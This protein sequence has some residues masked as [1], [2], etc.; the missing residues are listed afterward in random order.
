[1]N[2][3]RCIC[4]ICYLLLISYLLPIVEYASV[5]WDSCSEQDSVTQQKIQ[6]EATRLVTGIM[7]YVSLENLYK[8]CGWAT[9]SQRR[10]QHKLCF[11]YNVNTGMAPSYLQDLI[12]PLVSEVS[13]Y[14]LRNNRII[15]VP[16]NRTS[17]SQKSCIPSSIRLWNS[18][19]EI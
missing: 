10:Q 17:S 8:E 19:I 11:M 2:S 13:Y 5:L 4:L 16:Y 1:M 14:P 3:T 15:T 12:P 7:R 18:L 6:N 9:L